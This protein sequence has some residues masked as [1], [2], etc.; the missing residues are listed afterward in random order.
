MSSLLESGQLDNRSE[1]GTLA[2]AL[3]FPIEEGE[4]EMFK[5]TLSA[6][7]ASLMLCTAAYA[8]TPPASS[9]VGSSDLVQV[10]QGG[11]EFQDNK[12]ARHGDNWG[13]REASRYGS[14]DRYRSWHHYSS[15][16]G[17]WHDRGCVSVGP[18]WY[19][20]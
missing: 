9:N 10:R 3:C 19:C 16:P 18:M 11:K 12:Q 1:F 7:T 8:F 5:L 20:P 2:S 14:G 13:G 6:G 15:R 17:D 4:S